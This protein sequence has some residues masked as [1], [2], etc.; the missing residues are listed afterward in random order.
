M[1]KILL[2]DD[3][4]IITMQLEAF[5]AA[6]GFEVAGS[7]SSGEEAIDMARRF[8]PDLI[9]M[10]IVMPGKLDGIETAKV[11]KQERDVPVIFLTAY[12]DD[13][14]IDRSKAVS[15]HGYIVKPF[16]EREVK[17]TV[18]IALAKREL[19]KK[20]EESEERYRLLFENVSDTVYTVDQELRIT[21]I[22]PSVE[23]VLGYKPEEIIGKR[24]D[25]LDIIPPEYM[26]QAIQ[27]SLQALAGEAARSSLIE[28]IAKDG[29]RRFGE[30]NGAPL[31]RDGKII[32]YVD[33]ARDITERKRLQD[34]LLETKTYLENLINNAND[35]IYTMDF[36]GNLTFINSLGEK[37]TGYSKEQWLKTNLQEIF[38]KNDWR[39]CL[40][41]LEKLRAGKTV[42]D[43]YR[44]RRADG[45]FLVMSIHE[46]PILK[47]GKVV[48]VF[49]IGRDI[50]EKRQMEEMIRKERDKAQRYLDIAGV[51][52][53]VLDK[54]GNILLIN[55]KG[56]EILGYSKE[57]LLGKN[58]F[59]ILTPERIKAERKGIFRMLMAGET[60]LFEYQESI[61]LTKSGEERIIAWH[62]SPL[63]DEKG[64]IIGLLSSGN[65]I[66]AHRQAENKIRQQK[67]FLQTVI[68]SLT[69]PFY[70]INTDNHTI[71]MANSA[72]TTQDIRPGQTCFELLHKG[73]KQDEKNG[74]FGTLENLK[75]FGKS[76]T[77]EH[78]H[79]DNLGNPRYMEIHGYPITDDKGNVVQMIEYCLDITDRKL[80]EKALERSREE[81]K[82]LT[83]KLMEVQE[84][85]RRHI[86]RDFHDD[87]GQIAASVKMDM[88]ALIKT[89]E[90]EDPKTQKIA[91]GAR[92]KLD[93][94][95]AKIRRI[96]SMLRPP[97]LD[98]LGLI[99]ALE[100]CLQDF[101]ELTGITCIWNCEIE[102]GEYENDITTCLYRV[103]QEALSN[104]I[105]HAKASHVE[106]SLSLND[107]RLVLYVKDNGCG[108]HPQGVDPHRGLGLIGMRERLEQVGGTFRVSSKHNHGTAVEAE[109]PVR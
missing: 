85:E 10:D 12:T 75:K 100:S 93:A 33:V 109:V 94:L 54:E 23:K 37:L 7:A 74:N 103:M 76:I 62:N 78:I 99:P 63:T 69:H 71:E 13:K 73:K 97:L 68:E 15:P 2:V 58:H 14:Y 91:N 102:N 4:S 106:A 48:G 43:E 24:I 83:K 107:D 56:Y 6:T 47:A 26:E 16:S 108:F 87:L 52:M 53:E 82:L 5:L 1:P 27:N 55:R 70:V 18:E 51:I 84:E 80:A 36:D 38:H 3:E 61:L 9:L 49:G 25:E 31:I 66:T 59:D 11:I 46:V 67:E 95:L 35:V 29:T 19:E 98:E 57:E 44:V 96:S 17:A 92:R 65:D 88:E 21:S 72:A 20:L 64:E 77:T 39:K 22:S 8:M 90:Q 41:N 79:Y 32:A 45:Q 42:Q 40:D 105:H 28:F 81:T 101:E 34:E 60:G 89:T 86:S 104:I 50:T 30:T